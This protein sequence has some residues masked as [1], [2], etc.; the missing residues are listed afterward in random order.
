M[1]GI[2]IVRDY[3]QGSEK[4][5][6]LLGGPGGY[7][8]CQRAGSLNW[9]YAMKHKKFKVLLKIN[10]PLTRERANASK[11]WALRMLREGY[12]IIK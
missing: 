7:L 1:T 2:G 5:F 4:R 9:N 3:I 12:F 6:Y 8:D 10:R 11:D